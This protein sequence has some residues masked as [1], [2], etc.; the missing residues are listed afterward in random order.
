MLRIVTVY[1]IQCNKKSNRIS[2]K[3]MTILELVASMAIL[4]I[5]TTMLIVFIRPSEQIGKSR[6]E[7][8][9]S[10]LSVI[11]RAI[12]EFVLDHKRYPD[13]ENILRKS[14]TL[15]VGSSNVSNSNLGWILDN[16]SAYNSMLPIDPLNND[17]YY[18]SYT[19]SS[20]GYEINAKLEMLLDEMIQ[21]GG[22]DLNLY[23]I[24]NNLNLISP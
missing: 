10:D 2:Q 6:D 7:K 9:L 4:V 23:E 13:Q 5:L 16:L 3:G 24:G 15:P 12:S 14:N 20:T 11:D 17:E 22:N 1:K 19:H 18:Y 8:R 21:D